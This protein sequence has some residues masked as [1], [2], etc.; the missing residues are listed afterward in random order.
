MP[1]YKVEWKHLIRWAIHLPIGG[2]IAHMILRVDP[3]LGVV[4]AVYFLAYEV[5]EDW[6]VKDRS[7]ID[8]F[9]SLIMLIAGGYIIYIWF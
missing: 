3:T 4:I 1:S 5:M 6:R 9:G 7:F 2:V 8:V